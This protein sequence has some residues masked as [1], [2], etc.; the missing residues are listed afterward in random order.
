[1]TPAT[2][3]SLLRAAWVLTLGFAAALGVLAFQRWDASGSIDDELA[4]LEEDLAADPG[5]DDA[6]DPLASGVR[7]RMVDRYVFASRPEDR[8]RS[9]R[10]VLGDRVFF[11]SGDSVSVGEEFDGAEVVAVNAESVDF[12]KNGEDVTVQ[13]QGSGGGGDRVS[14]RGGGGRNRGGGGWRGRRGGGGDGGGGGGGG[15]GPGGGDRPR[16]GGPS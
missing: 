7:D 12:R 4:A 10:G 9:V 8:F 6:D 1:M 11:S 2:R 14:G 16:R 3:N 13:V 5:G 15:G